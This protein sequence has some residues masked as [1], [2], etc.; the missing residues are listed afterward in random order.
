MPLLALES[1]TVTTPPVTSVPAVL[2]VAKPHVTYIH[3]YK[4]NSLRIAY[5][6]NPVCPV[7]FTKK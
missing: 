5:G 2:P 6:I 3:C 4:G 7:G 1:I